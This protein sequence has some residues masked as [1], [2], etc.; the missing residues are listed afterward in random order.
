MALYDV[1][2]DIVAALV[3]GCPA[4]AGLSGGPFGAAATY[5]PGRTVAGVRIS[6]D[7]VEVHVVARYG[8][9]VGE[10]AGQVRSVLAG[11]VLGRTVDIVVEDLADRPDADP[12]P[13]APALPSAA[14]GAVVTTGLAAPPTVL[15]A[16]GATGL[17]TPV[18]VGA[19]PP[20]GQVVDPLEVL[21]AGEVPSTLPA[22]PDPPDPPAVRPSRGTRPGRQG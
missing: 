14:T 16:A 8:P 21:A 11:R 5:L 3:L 13:A 18:P 9:T 6:P 19:S 1:D 7:T 10:L 2:P 12:A 22:P 15:P 20:A 17:G 4:V